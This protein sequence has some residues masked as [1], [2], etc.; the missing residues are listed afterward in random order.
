MPKGVAL[1]ALAFGA[2]ASAA[3]GGTPLGAQ[4]IAPPERAR[5]VV[6]PAAYF[7]RLALDPTAFRLPNGLFR[8]GA[9]GEPMP[10]STVGNKGML[11][12]PALF[13][14][15]PEPH[16]SSLQ[17]QQLL[18]DG[19]APRGTLTAAYLEMSRGRL[20]V[21]GKVL[22]WVR[23][24]MPLA[25]V[26]GTTA[27]IGNDAQM[28]PYLI[29]ALMAA[30]DQVDFG[31]YDNDGPDGIPNSGDDDGLVD[32]MA[33]QFIEVAGSCGGPGIWPHRWGVS[34]QNGGEPFWSADLRP[35]GLP[36]GVDGYIVQSAV[37]CGG[38]DALDAAT[39]AH[40][41]GHV[42]GLPDYY[43]PTANGA[44]GRRWVLGCWELMAAGSWGCGPHGSN[45]E[46]FGPSH[47]SAR[48]K[49]VMGWLD[50]IPV[51]EV[52]DKEFVLWPVQ[53]SGV[54][55]S[56]PL[57]ATG[58]EHLLVE[59]RSK[60]GFDAGIPAEGLLIYHQD[61]AGLLRPNPASGTPYFL[62]LV[63]QDDNRGLVRNTLEGG[64]RGEA[65]D[66]WGVG[67]SVQAYHFGTTPSLRLN[68]GSRATTVTFHELAV[69]N[70]Q[71]RIRLST[72]A[73]PKVMAPTEPLTVEQ[74]V[75]FELRLR[76]AG[77]AMPYQ[78]GGAVPPGVTMAA[79][80]DAVVV[81]GTVTSAGPFEVAPRVTD[82]RGSVSPALSI[83]LMAGAW[84]VGED[85]L[86]QPF[87]GSAA[88]P[89]T[90]G[91]R[92]YLDFAGNGNGRY[93]VGDLRARLRQ[94]AASA[95]G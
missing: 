79:D 16:V 34:N 44:E 72:G 10:V 88:T 25:Q 93:D 65:G 24:S 42:L 23:T 67:G 52:W 12:L 91:E 30:D 83:P 37:N 4:D 55:L 63:E 38:V 75:P 61:N 73:T 86:L 11:V 46:P 7:E 59:Y 82:A 85:R 89:L 17:M 95:G 33:F 58:R 28:G 20:S 87:L 6:L 41:Y 21:E 3:A 84:Q 22:P 68:E 70:G 27:G 40:E 9:V 71:A 69:A 26:V 49:N 64:N 50:L 90:A 66:A 56:V 74:V 32:A 45:R 2:A 78:V 77:G 54:A 94:A 19:P 31:A 39:I 1:V 14:D 47:M 5:G 81:R 92:S 51:G 62:A 76:V 18:F 13:E 48:S 15:S 29:Q 60:S 36:V 80:G 53:Q 57:D 8:V 35:N 43:H